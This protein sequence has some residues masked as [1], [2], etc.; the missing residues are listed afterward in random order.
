M[1]NTQHV[2]H[3]PVHLFLI[4]NSVLDKR[5]VRYF[6]LSKA[7]RPTDACFDDDLLKPTR[8]LSEVHKTCWASDV[9]RC[10]LQATRS[11]RFPLGTQHTLA[12]GI[13]H[14]C[15]LNESLVKYLDLVLIVIVEF[16]LFDSPSQLMC[17]ESWPAVPCFLNLT[18]QKSPFDDD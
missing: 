3:L 6:N 8:V 1:R 2:V 16:P 12:A 14:R 7:Y 10:F 9:I 18:G 17:D 5:T 13:M 11:G 4:H 15:F